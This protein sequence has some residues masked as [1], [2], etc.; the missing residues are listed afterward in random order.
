MGLLVEV[1]VR[2]P[3][4]DTRILDVPEDFHQS[5]GF[6]SWRT[7]V[8]GSELVRS[9]GARFLPVP[10]G[11]N[12]EVEAARV[13]DFLREVALLRARPDLIA[14]GTRRPRTAEEHRDRIQDR[15][16][17]NEEAALRA[18]VIGGGVLVR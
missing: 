8:W 15:L 1:F 11:R 12:P 4:G 2:G 18:L 6:E 17:I 10:A 7:T 13:P 5:A 14:F 3:D 9:P 16:R